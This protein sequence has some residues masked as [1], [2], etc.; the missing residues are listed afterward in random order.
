MLAKL[1]ANTMQYMCDPGRTLS[2]MR[3]AVAPSLGG[4]DPFVA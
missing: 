4:L 3:G 2:C 1:L